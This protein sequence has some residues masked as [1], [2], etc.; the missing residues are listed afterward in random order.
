MI[1]FAA[2]I[3]RNEIA[4]ESGWLSWPV[5]FFG[6]KS[7]QLLLCITDD[8][9]PKVR[10][11]LLVDGLPAR[12]SRSPRGL[13]AQ[14]GRFC[15]GARGAPG[16]RGEPSPVRFVHRSAPKLFDYEVLYAY[17]HDDEA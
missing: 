7:E 6:P 13:W 3:D 12:R 11:R 15:W 9:V 2:P 16:A 4:C 14:G 8:R 10:P 1:C 5:P 17:L